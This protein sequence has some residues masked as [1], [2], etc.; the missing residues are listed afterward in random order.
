MRHYC[1]NHRIVNK[2]ISAAWSNHFCTVTRA[3]DYFGPFQPPFTSCL[4]CRFHFISWWH[5]FNLF[6]PLVLYQD[7]R[8]LLKVEGKS[9]YQ[10]DITVEVL[11]KQCIPTTPS[12]ISP[13]LAP[14]LP[15]QTHE[16]QPL[17]PEQDFT[18]FL[19]LPE[20][21]S[22][23]SDFFANDFTKADDL[24]SQVTCIINNNQH[25]LLSLI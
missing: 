7:C 13:P 12:Q 10:E 3:K 15:A 14:I 20:A 23:S 22:F 1:Y 11:N 24:G 19:P 5:V 25:S 21:W 6:W 8:V 18:Q 4:C 17:Q 16:P 2:K 9:T